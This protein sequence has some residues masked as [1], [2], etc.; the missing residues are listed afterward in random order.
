V[1]V[2][3][4][5]PTAPAEVPARIAGA[6]VCLRRNP[7]PIGAAASRNKALEM[8]HPEV[9]A[10]G[11]LDDDVR[12]SGDWFGVVRVELT[13]ARGAITGPVQRFDTG[14][15]ARARQLRYDARYRP[16]QPF[17]EVEF[18][19]GGNAV[20]WRST[21]ELAGGFPRVATMSDTLL[22]RR[23]SEVDTPCHY[24]PELIVFHRNSKGLRQACLTA[25]QAGWIEGRRGETTYYQR[26]A[27]GAKGVIGSRDPV[28]A[29]L[30]VALD[31][32]F[33]TAHATN[34]A[35][36]LR[37]RSVRGVPQVPKSRLGDLGCSRARD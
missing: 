25:W 22:A 5:S 24:V 35:S 37:S 9:N 27:K 10:I 36:L 11:F 20:V 15:V 2:V 1:V 17:Q 4:D 7:E 29:A 6:A 32:V 8:V 21:L 13:R 23:L 19:A 30:N 34:R 3:D 12:L 18:L 14:L 33:L 16:L 31:A 26:L 28:A